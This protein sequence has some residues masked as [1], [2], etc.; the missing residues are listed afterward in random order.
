M[1]AFFE[2][3]T[4]KQLKR[5]FRSE[6]VKNAKLI[7]MALDPK[8]QKAIGTT[9]VIV[10]PYCILRCVCG[11]NACFLFLARHHRLDCL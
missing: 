11:P 8:Y 1:E 5:K 3:R 2:N 10:K 6:S 9:I 7:E 4:R